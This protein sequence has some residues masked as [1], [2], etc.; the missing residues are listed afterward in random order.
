MKTAAE[1]KRTVRE[2]KRKAGF[3]CKH[4]WIRPRDWPK[5]QKYLARFA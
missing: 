5:V 1:L 2:N 3:V 4:V